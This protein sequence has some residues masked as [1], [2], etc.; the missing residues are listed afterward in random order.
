MSESVKVL[1]CVPFIRSF[2]VLVRES[3]TINIILKTFPNI[4][5]ITK[6]IFLYDGAQ[7]IP[8]LTFGEAKIQDNS[9]IVIG[10]KTDDLSINYYLISL[11]KISRK[12]EYVTKILNSFYEKDKNNN[13][14][15]S[16][17]EKKFFF[18]EHMKS[19]YLQID[20]SRVKKQIE[21]PDTQNQLL[22]EPLPILF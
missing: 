6:L 1:V 21:I 7:L 17:S 14:N 13:R 15:H 20:F 4:Q 2:L 12:P 18:I 5:D 11:S 10:I 16:L 8:N 9:T 19:L 22:C 3:Q